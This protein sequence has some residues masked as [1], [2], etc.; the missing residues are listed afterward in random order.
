MEQKLK[1]KGKYTIKSLKDGI[2]LDTIIIENVITDV[3]LNAIIEKIGDISSTSL[4]QFIALGTGNT[5]PVG[6]D[7]QLEAETYREPPET[8]TRV[9]SSLRL[10]T[11]LDFT[12]GNDITFREIGI[13]GLDAT[14]VS[15]T[16]TLISRALIDPPTGKYKSP[17][18]ELDIQWELEVLRS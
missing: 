8:I 16:G 17:G 2:L 5:A 1:F 18:T 13:F 6:A 11:T 3:G 15:G 14:A 4:F 9:G 7:T 12:E 10:T